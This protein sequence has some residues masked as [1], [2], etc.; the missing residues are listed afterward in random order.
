MT[1]Q[2]TYGDDVRAY[3]ADKASAYD[4]VDHQPYWVLS[5]RLLAAAL[6]EL[7]LPAL[8]ADFHFLDA[9]GGTGRWTSFM[10]QAAPAS[11]GVLYDLTPEM[12]AVAEQK[13]AR[14]GFADRMRF[15][16]ADLTDVAQTLRGQTFDLIF[17]FHNVLGFVADPGQV[18][19]GLAELLRPGGL[20]VTFLP[21]RWHT[22]Y[23]NISL[24]KV[25]EAQRAL[26]GRGRFTD[27]MPDMHLYDPQSIR[28]LHA[29]AG[30]TVDVLTGFPCLIYPGYQETQLHGSTGELADLLDGPTTDRIFE[31][32]NEAR[33][34]KDIAARG[35]NLFTVARKSA[36]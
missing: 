32:E 29:E 7:V 19:T 26:A 10:A 34:S 20:L 4:D 30:L 2:E 27:T 14:L 13:A 35:N 22:A 18:V 5:D 15:V 25:D 11:Q 16:N 6:T 23:F 17:S 1:L 8:P 33:R 31:L 36:S 3:F 28:S 24:G 12:L 9:G 21:N